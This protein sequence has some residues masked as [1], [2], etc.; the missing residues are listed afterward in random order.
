MSTFKP[1]KALRPIPDKAKAIASMPYDVMDSDEA[2]KEVQ[3]NPLS[4]LH[5]EKP[6]V[7]LPSGTDLYDPAVYAKARENLYKYVSDGYMKQDAQPAYYIYKQ[8]MDGRA[9]IGLVG[10]TSVDEYMDGTI[11]KHELT[12][13][14]KEADRIRHIA[15]CDAHPSPVFFTY[16]HQDVI[17]NTVAKVMANKQP[18][19]DFI[20]DDSI[21][22]TLWV[23]DDPEDIKAIQN[24]FTSLPNLYVADG[25]HR[26]ASAAKVGL[27]KREQFPDYTGDEEFNYFMA[28]IFP[29]NQLKIYDYNR[30]VKDLNGLTKEEFLAKIAEKWNVTP[31]P[32]GNNFAPQKKHNISM[33]LDGK[34]Y[35]LEP[36][37]GTWN[38]KNIVEDL[39]VSILQNNL[40]Q[41][42]LGIN[43]PRTDQRIDFI[44][45]IRGLGELVK[46][47]DSGRETVAFAMYPTSMDELLG[48]A[49]AGEIMPPKS[50]WFEPK[51]RSGLFIHL[52]K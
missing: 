20:S 21:H 42:V 50:T 36:K 9:Q 1:F 18:E 25:H 2:R 52:L 45:G 6:E 27:K 17:D 30:V 26:T 14:E 43:D 29:D 28:V 24:A 16:R 34:W 3:K 46:R 32:E 10:L 39:D 51:L 37:P 11:K 40:L 33:Y 5:V 22:H 44:G 47:V 49:D 38:E 12:R 19:Y 8:V 15:A 13:A 23:M 4:F 41:P 35:R 31:I 7:D 48:I